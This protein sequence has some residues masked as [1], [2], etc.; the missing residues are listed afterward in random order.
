M[1]TLATLVLGSTL[2]TTSA[3]DAPAAAEAPAAEQPVVSPLQERTERR[4]RRMAKI[5]TV[6][7]VGLEVGAGL[8]HVLTA[9]TFIGHDSSCNGSDSQCRMGTPIVVFLPAGAITL[10]WIGAARLAAGREASIWRSPLFWA[11]TGVTLLAPLA[12][13]A[14][15]S[16]MFNAGPGSRNE[17]VAADATIVAG[18]VLGNVIEVWG[19]FTAPP[20]DTPPAAR[21]LSLA[22]GCAPTSGGI[23]CGLALAHF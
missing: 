4:R 13:A 9:T 5:H 20:R 10:G 22:P 19:A 15:A 2:A 11:G 23:V 1:L 18:F 17:R 8:L 6:A 14:V 3:A 12:A 21:A 7:G 16:A